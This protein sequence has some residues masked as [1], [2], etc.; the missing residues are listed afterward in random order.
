M[1]QL[2]L[3]IHLECRLIQLVGWAWYNEGVP[4]WSYTRCLAIPTNWRTY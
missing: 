4:T 3:A 1:A 2:A